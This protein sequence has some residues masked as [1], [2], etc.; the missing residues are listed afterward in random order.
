MLNVPAVPVVTIVSYARLPSE[1][2]TVI[3]TS[4]PAPGLDVVV[5]V[6][7]PV[8]VTNAPGA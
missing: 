1:S 2:V 7:V 5:S 8:M 6:N 4:K 3:P